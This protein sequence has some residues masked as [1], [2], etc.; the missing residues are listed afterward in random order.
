MGVIKMETL[1]CSNVMDSFGFPSQGIFSDISELDMIDVIG[2]SCGGGIGG[3]C[4]NCY[5]GCFCDG[6]WLG[7]P[8]FG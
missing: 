4:S 5:L 1:E 2:G 8:V 6:L 7:S 3:G